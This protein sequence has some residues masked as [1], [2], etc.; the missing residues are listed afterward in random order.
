[1]C[2]L[3]IFYLTKKQTSI[4]RHTQKHIQNYFIIKF[5]CVRVCLVLLTK[6]VHKTNIQ[7]NHIKTN[8]YKK[9]YN[10]IINNNNKKRRRIK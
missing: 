1:M 6:C 2:K 9:K 5:V 4:T 3:K 10:K 8:Q 7:Q